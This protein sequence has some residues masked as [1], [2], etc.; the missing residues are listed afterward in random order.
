MELVQT[1]SLRSGG[2]STLCYKE[3]D[4]EQY[5][6]YDQVQEVVRQIDTDEPQQRSVE[7]Q[8]WDETE[9]GEQEVDATYHAVVQP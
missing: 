5:R 6:A 9:H 1:R 3:T 7:R 8:S 2:C 4:D